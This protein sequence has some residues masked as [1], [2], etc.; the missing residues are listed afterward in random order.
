MSE[1]DIGFI[2]YKNSCL[3]I[4]ID[5]IEDLSK[6]TVFINIGLHNFAYKHAIIFKY[7]F[8]KNKFHTQQVFS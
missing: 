6:I 7:L 1:Y 5:P 3:W 8:L 2:H 4:S